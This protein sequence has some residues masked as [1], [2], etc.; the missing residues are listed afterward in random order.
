MNGDTSG[1]GQQ[2][3]APQPDRAAL[4]QEEEQTEEHRQA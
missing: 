3:H 2:T 4:F 1:G